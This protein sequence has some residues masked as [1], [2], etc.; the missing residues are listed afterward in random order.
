MK[1]DV[2]EMLE[3]LVDF[4]GDFA[5]V[6]AESNDDRLEQILQWMESLEESPWPD[7]D[8]PSTSFL[9]A[10]QFAAMIRASKESR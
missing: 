9:E 7:G 6:T 3:K 2:N 5:E 4:A 1:Y 10:K 8:G